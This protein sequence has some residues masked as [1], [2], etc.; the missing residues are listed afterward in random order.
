MLI[1]FAPAAKY[2]PENGIHSEVADS[3]RWS[4][5]IV[6]HFYMMT[7]R[8]TSRKTRTSNIRQATIDTTKN[9]RSGRNTTQEVTPGRRY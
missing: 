6:F 2:F 7:G 1:P 9:S 4:A 8:A 5:T 3:Y